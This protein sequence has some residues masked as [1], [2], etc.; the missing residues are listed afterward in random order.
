MPLFFLIPIPLTLSLAKLEAASIAIGASALAAN[1]SSAPIPSPFF[2]RPLF[3]AS[4]F[5]NTSFKVLG[6]TRKN[7]YKGGV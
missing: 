4:G 2:F 1:L 6:F 5:S 7:G 3:L